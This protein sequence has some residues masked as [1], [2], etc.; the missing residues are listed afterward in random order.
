[1]LGSLRG[2]PRR[3]QGSSSRKRIASKVAPPHIS[4]G[5]CASRARA[6]ATSSMSWCGRRRGATGGVAEGRVGDER[7]LVVAHPRRSLPP[8]APRTSAEPAGGGLPV[9]DGTDGDRGARP[10]R[11]ARR[12]A[13]VHGRQIGEQ[14]RADPAIL[15]ELE[16]LGGLGDEVVAVARLEGRVLDQ[17]EVGDVRLD[18]T[19]AELAEGPERPGGGF[20]R[21]RPRVVSLASSES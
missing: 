16:E 20:S 13:T 8:R 14:A 4:R 21:S 19:H 18:A 5:A 3:R 2:A 12:R 15:L 7:R 11:G 10:G 6:G 9:V 17:R 1:M